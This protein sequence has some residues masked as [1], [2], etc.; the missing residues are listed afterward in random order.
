MKKT[1]KWGLHI[2]HCFFLWGHLRLGV[3]EQGR[4]H[5]LSMQ[6]TTAEVASL[7]DDDDA[8]VARQH[9]DSLVMSLSHLCKPDL[10][11]DVLKYPI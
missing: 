1:G 9:R 10:C 11:S 2:S 3:P 7:G 8:H 6:V 5:G 4:S